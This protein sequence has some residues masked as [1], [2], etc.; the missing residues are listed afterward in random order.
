MNICVYGAASN[1]I[2]KIYIDKCYELGAE[3][4]KRNIT[5][6][7]GAGAG[8]VMGACARGVF[9]E[10][11]T[12]IGVVPRFFDVD[13]VRFDKCTETI[14][15]K[16]MRERKQTMEDRSDAFIV[17]PGGIG[18][19][20]EFFEIF[21]LQS[22]GRHEKPIVIFN[23]NGYYDCMLE[24]LDS[25]AKAGFISKEALDRLLITDDINEIFEM[26]NKFEY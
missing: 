1:K 4:A 5:M 14:F 18:T 8:G 10:N 13:G 19:F 16:D 11:G 15:T 22:L 3:L 20:D 2:D 26:I 12:M 17:A 24:N 6:I 7:F 23:V 9:S 25:A 21:T